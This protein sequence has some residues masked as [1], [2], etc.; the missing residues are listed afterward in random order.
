MNIHATVEFEPAISVGE[1][2]LGPILYFIWCDSPWWVKTSFTHNDP[3]GWVI[4]PI[5][6]IYASVAFETMI[7]TGERPLELQ[8]ILFGVTAL[9]GQDF[10][11]HTQLFLRASD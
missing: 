5:T 3:S 6:D 4:S 10:L 1:R 11:I 9:V 7:S 2:P 8:R